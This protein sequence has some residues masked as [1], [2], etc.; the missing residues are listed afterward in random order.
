MGK[1]EDSTFAL[2]GPAGTLIMNDRPTF[3]WQALAG[4]ISYKVSVLDTSFNVVI[5]SAPVAQ[6]EWQAS[7]ALERNKIYLW[8]VTAIR[9]GREVIAPISPQ[10]EA[11]FK[12]I[13]QA[14]ARE[15]RQPA[16][17]SH[18]RAG[19]IYAHNG[20]LDDAERELQTAIEKGEQSAL[21][22]KLLESVKAM[23]R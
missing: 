18:L 9:D 1:G 7:R 11:R 15:L 12:I 10:P 21:A 2:L 14:K 16:N 20:L 4:A 22:G 23:R 6:T 13:S 5:E 17:E 8:Q 19:I 3:R